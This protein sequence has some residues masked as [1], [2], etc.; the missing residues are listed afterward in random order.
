MDG[1]TGDHM[2]TVAI[3]ENS[4]F[5]G[6]YFRPYIEAA[7]YAWK[8]VRAWRGE[9]LSAAGFSAFI[10]TGDFHNVTNGLKSYHER[11]LELLEHAGG[12]R[13]Y[14]SCFSHQMIAQSRGGTVERR[15]E[16]LLGWERLS[17]EGNHC[18]LEGMDSFPALCLN[19]DEVTVP[20]P[21]ATMVA[22]SPKCRCQALSYGDGIL[23]CQ[24]HPELSLERA[25]IAVSAAALFLSMG[26]P[27]A[28]RA[29]RQTRSIASDAESNEFMKRVIRWL[30]AT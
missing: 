8:T 15:L 17:V 5:T 13:T 11:E 10:L 22:A 30:T 9:P 20:P 4:P 26:R 27:T 14:A 3:I 7:G 21:G 29:F 12:R 23:T 25:G 2:F 24:A 16:R 18:V 19:V 28:Y 1:L 6:R